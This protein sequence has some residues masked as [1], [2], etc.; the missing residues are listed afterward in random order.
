MKEVI[1]KSTDSKTFTLTADGKDIGRLKYKNW[2]SFKAQ[3]ELA[4]YSTVDIV[5]VGFWGTTVE[6]K[7]DD[8]VLLRFQMNW[9]GNIIINNYFEGEKEFIFK[10][11]GLLKSNYVLMDK[12]E[13]QLLIVEPDFKWAGL[14]YDYTI[15]SEQ[16]FKNKRDNDLMLFAIVHCTNYY[17]SMVSSAAAG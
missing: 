5:T 16:I 9:K 12:N 17:M 11:Q 6:M 3:V 15:E 4:D 2:F 14:K 1:A 8:K 7:R 13:N 10:H